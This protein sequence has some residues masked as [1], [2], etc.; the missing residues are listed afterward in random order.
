MFIVRLDGY[1]WV[2]P[3]VIEPDGETVFLKTAFWSL[4]FNRKYGE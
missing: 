1:V 3:F 4:K 2:V